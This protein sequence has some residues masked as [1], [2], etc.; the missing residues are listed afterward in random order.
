MKVNALREA[1]SIIQQD[2]A[3]TVCVTLSF[4]TIE[5]HVD[6]LTTVIEQNLLFKH[7]LIVQV[8]GQI[9]R[10]R[11]PYR[12]HGFLALLRSEGVSFGY[13]IMS[14]RIGMDVQA[15]DQIKPDFGVLRAP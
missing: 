13:R 6:I 4:G 5:R 15:L 14:P 10:A 1:L 2:K 9:E 8:C 3:G 11:S 12:V 7:R